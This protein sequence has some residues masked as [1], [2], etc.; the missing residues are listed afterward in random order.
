MLA[1][2]L[3]A[4][5]VEDGDLTVRD[6]ALWVKTLAGLRPVHVVIRRQEGR[7]VDPLE[8]PGDT[9]QGVPGLLCAIRADAVQVMNAPGA[10]FAEAPALAAFLP[11]LAKRLLGE[12]L[13]MPSHDVLWLGDASS[14]AAVENDLSRYLI[15][16]DREGDTGASR[17]AAMDI[18]ARQRLLASIA[19]TPWAFTA[20][21]PPRPSFAPCTGEGDTL[22]PKSLVVRLFPHVRRRSMAAAARRPRQGP[23][24]NR[25]ARRPAAAIRPLQGRLGTSGG[26]QRHLRPGQFASPRAGDPPHR[27]RHTEP[28]R[29]QFLLARPLSRA[30]RKCR[31][32]HP[33]DHDPPL[34]RRPSAAR[35]PRPRGVGRLPGRR[36]HRQ[37]RLYPSGWHRPSGRHA[38]ARHAP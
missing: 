33:R 16:S 26:G 2:E 31:A 10:G 32:P 29:R 6:G 21:L 18:D 13:A 28:G 35:H 34:T 22:E 20:S 38:P 8:L 11:V 1:R 9:A 27:R 17:P 3:N 7:S 14:R 23:H 24:R 37:R 15:R 25:A 5:L 30:V 36:R 12:P 19:E 4:A